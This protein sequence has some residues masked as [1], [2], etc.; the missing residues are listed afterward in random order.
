MFRR[1]VQDQAIGDISEI[2]RLLAGTDPAAGELGATAPAR[3]A[4]IRE[5]IS[6]GPAVTA[7][8]RAG[9][10]AVTSASAAGS[11]SPA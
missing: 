2:R 6:T 7:G 3:L 8:G 11:S 4:L 10:Q 9:G 5:Q 1:F